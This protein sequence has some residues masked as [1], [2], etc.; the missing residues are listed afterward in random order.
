[1]YNNRF[2]PGIRIPMIM[3]ST[4]NDIESGR[5]IER[6]GEQI[7]RGAEEGLAQTPMNPVNKTRNKNLTEEALNFFEKRCCSDDITGGD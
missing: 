4:Y 1:M 7:L 5:N 2:Q 6:T 3:Y